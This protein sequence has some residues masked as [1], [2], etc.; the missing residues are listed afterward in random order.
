[1]ALCSKYGACSESRPPVL[2]QPIRTQGSARRMPGSDE[3]N[4]AVGSLELGRSE[5][6]RPQRR[7]VIAPYCFVS[8]R[9]NAC[10][11]GGGLASVS[12]GPLR[13]GIH[14]SYD[15]LAIA[16]HARRL[17]HEQPGRSLRAVAEELGVDR[18]TAQRALHQYQGTTARRLNADFLPRRVYELL[19]TSPSRSIKEVAHALGYQSSASFCRRIRQLEGL[20]ASEIRRID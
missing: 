13:L 5:A 8:L 12:V 19:H 11:V 20:S 4:V 9:K 1:M 14:M 10:P 16:N 6:Y 15:L 2:Q 18:R 7:G 17:I 3:I